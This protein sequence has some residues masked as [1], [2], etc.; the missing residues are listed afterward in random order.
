MLY[1]AQ[2]Q[3]Q[4]SSGETELQILAYETADNIWQ[5]NTSE[6]LTLNQDI[7]L[8]EGVLV[9]VE[10]EQNGT[11]V[12]IKEAK[13]WILTILQQYLTKNAINPQFIAEEQH[14]IEQWRQEITAQNLELNRRFL[15]IETRR[16]ELQQ[17]EQSLKSKEEELQN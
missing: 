12:S 1:L 5:V 15:E 14:K 7:S 8:Q 4:P 3:K 9:L 13:D 11:V 2:V 10:K 6:S 16:E 17:L